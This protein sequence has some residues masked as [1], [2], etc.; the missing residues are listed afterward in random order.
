[1]IVLGYSGAKNG[2]EGLD[3]S[4]K[5]LVQSGEIDSLCA[6]ETTLR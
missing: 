1:M 4:K 2:S 5:K 6:E 3:L